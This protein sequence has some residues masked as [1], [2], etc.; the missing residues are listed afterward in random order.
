MQSI[1]NAQKDLWDLV[2]KMQQRMKKR[3]CRAGKWPFSHCIMHAFSLYD[4]VQLMFIT[5]L[6]FEHEF[7]N[8]PSPVICK[9]LEQRLPGPCLQMPVEMAE[10]LN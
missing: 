4:T 2:G 7:M 1:K 5:L 9:S 10:I 8:I 3:S 6:S